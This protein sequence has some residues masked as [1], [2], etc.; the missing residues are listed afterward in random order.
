M[1]LRIVC[2]KCMED[3]NEN[4]RPIAFVEFRDDGRYEVTCPKGH[5]AIVFLQQQKFELLFEIGAYAIADG[6]YREAVSSFAASLSARRVLHSCSYASEVHRP[7]SHRCRRP[8]RRLLPSL[9]G[10]SVPSHFFTLLSL[11][12][13]RSCLVVRGSH[14]ETMS[15][16]RAGSPRVP[17]RSTMVKPSSTPSG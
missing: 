7:R 15:S 3:S 12:D 4:A 5:Q 11:V 13:R 8:G 10:N 6:Y 9:S 16:T 2:P 14:S 17:K 1:K